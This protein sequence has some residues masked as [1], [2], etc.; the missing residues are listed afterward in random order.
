MVLVL[1]LILEFLIR[2]PNYVDLMDSDKAF[3]PATA[4]FM[5]KYHFF[6][7]SLA[8]GLFIPQ[9]ICGLYGGCRD[10]IFLNEIQSSLWAC[11]NPNRSKAMLGRFLLGLTFLRSFGLARYW[12]QMWLNHTCVGKNG[13][14]C[15]FAFLKYKPR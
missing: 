6:C 1:E 15:K 4:R 3:A 7:E 9:A 10:V 12:K 13:E 2:P 14:S 5:N 8:L 11:T